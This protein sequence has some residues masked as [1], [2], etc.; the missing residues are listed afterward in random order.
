MVVSAASVLEI[1]TLVRRGRLELSLPL[2]QWITDLRAL[3]ELR[4]EPV[5]ADIALLAGSF[6]A[7]DPRDPADRMIAATA[8]SEGCPLVTADAALRAARLVETIW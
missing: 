1:A 4:I 6:S 2:A 5:S 3:P 8:W 7:E